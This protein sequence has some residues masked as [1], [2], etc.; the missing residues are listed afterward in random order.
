M[1]KINTDKQFLGTGWGF[2]PTFNKSA[3]GMSVEMVSNHQDINESLHI[4]LD[5][6]P[7]ERVMFPTYGCGIKRMVFEK[8]DESMMTALKDTIAR[9]ILFFEPRITLDSIDVDLRDQFNGCVRFC[10]NYTV[11]TTNNR[12]NIVYPYYINEG[13]NVRL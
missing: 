12:S 10:L 1:A 13:S 3:N 8:I 2:P 9:A 4:L 5:T 6:A 11:R 7:G